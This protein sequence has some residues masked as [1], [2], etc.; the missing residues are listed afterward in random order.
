MLPHR[1]LFC[2]VHSGTA[3]CWEHVCYVLDSDAVSFHQ[4]CEIV[5][6]LVLTNACVKYYAQV[7][8]MQGE[9][10]RR[11]YECEDFWNVWWDRV[12]DFVSRLFEDNVSGL[13]RFHLIS[14]VV[15]CFPILI[16][17]NE[18]GSVYDHSTHCVSIGY[19]IH[20]PLVVIEFINKVIYMGLPSQ[21]LID[22]YTQEFGC[23]T[24]RNC[25]TI[26][27]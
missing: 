17:H 15:S 13:Y 16:F 25:N 24:H 6:L 14:S 7:C 23:I 22:M 12:P 2:I 20:W 11:L 26:Y 5:Q 18:C 9:P 19:L 8:I 4:I 21:A 3:V 10:C 1:K 27:V